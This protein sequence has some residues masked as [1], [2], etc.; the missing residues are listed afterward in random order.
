MYWIWYLAAILSL[1]RVK[2][3]KVEEY[4]VEITEPCGSRTYIDPSHIDAIWE[5]LSEDLPAVMI[6]VGRN[7]LKLVM[8]YDMLMK[9]LKV[10]GE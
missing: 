3:N 6:S 10:K 8:P 2:G 4:F 1:T 7:T 5:N 9:Q